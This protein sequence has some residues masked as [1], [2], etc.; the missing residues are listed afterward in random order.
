M[1]IILKKN[2]IIVFRIEWKSSTAHNFQINI[3]KDN[4]KYV[5]AAYRREVNKS[6]RRI[7]VHYVNDFLFH[8]NFS[9]YYF[10]L[11]HLPWKFETFIC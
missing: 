5:R 8:I 2:N 4:S 3:L 11:I 10:V 7:T 1:V 9:L 6:L